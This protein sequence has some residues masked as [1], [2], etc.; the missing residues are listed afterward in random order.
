M[1]GANTFLRHNHKGFPLI[2]LL[3]LPDHCCLHQYVSRK[4][5]NCESPTPDLKVE[6]SSSARLRRQLHR[7]S[8]GKQWKLIKKTGEDTKRKREEAD[9]GKK[10]GKESRW[11]I[12]VWSS[13]LPPCP[14]TRPSLLLS[15]HSVT[16]MSNTLILSARRCF[17]CFD[18][19]SLVIQ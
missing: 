1:K 14:H 9:G 6:S 13:C 19:F 11:V 5:K 4:N 15:L 18:F 16:P 7:A 2:H 12:L 10:D 3:S 17:L 8:D